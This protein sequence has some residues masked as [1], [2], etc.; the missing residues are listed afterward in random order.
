MNK[1]IKIPI[2]KRETVNLHLEVI[3]KNTKAVSIYLYGNEYGYFLGGT[4][5]QGVIKD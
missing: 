2:T 3:R 5:F 1:I 4:Q